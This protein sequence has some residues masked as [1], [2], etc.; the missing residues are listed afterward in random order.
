MI[1]FFNPKQ[2]SLLDQKEK[3]I[4]PFGLRMKPILEATDISL[5]TIHDTIYL[6]S[7]TWLLKQP[8]TMF[9]LKKIYP[10]YQNIFTDGS[11][12]NYGTGCGAVLHKKTLKKMPPKRSFH[13][14]CRNLC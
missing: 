13:I 6:S 3:T 7:P 2:L 11:K 5:T 14:F 10:N 1:A 9:D 12:S 8:V 4:K